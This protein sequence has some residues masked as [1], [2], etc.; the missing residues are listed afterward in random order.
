[1]IH[2]HTYIKVISIVLVRLC[3]LAVIR[4]AFQLKTHVTCKQHMKHYSAVHCIV[5]HYNCIVVNC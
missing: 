1:M 2:G 5:L 4:V 3:F